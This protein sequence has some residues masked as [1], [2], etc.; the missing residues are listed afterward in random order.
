MMQVSSEPR[1]A[2]LLSQIIDSA[3]GIQVGN[4]D[5]LKSA[6]ALQNNACTEAI[7]D[8]AL[9]AKEGYFKFLNTPVS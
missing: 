2:A 5:L 3:Q 4:P 6:H 7:C 1:L 8:G 9:R